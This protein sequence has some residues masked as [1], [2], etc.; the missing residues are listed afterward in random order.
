MGL[1]GEYTGETIPEEPFEFVPVFLRRQA[2]V[3]DGSE[4]RCEDCGCRIDEVWTDMRVLTDLE[5]QRQYNLLI[6]VCD[7]CS[8]GREEQ[9]GMGWRAS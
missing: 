2:P 1:R 7:Q 8:D 5:G 9:R 4:R 3:H 6:V